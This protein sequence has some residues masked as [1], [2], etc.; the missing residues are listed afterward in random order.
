MTL[1]LAGAMASLDRG[2]SRPAR[3]LGASRL[4]V[5]VEIVLPQVAADAARRPRPVLRDDAV[6]AVGAA[7][8]QPARSRRCS[9]STWRSASTR[10]GDYAVANA[11]GLSCS[12]CIDA[13]SARGSTCGTRCKATE[14]GR[15]RRRIAAAALGRARLATRAACSRAA[16]PS[17]CSGRS[18]TSCC[19]RSPSAG[20]PVQAAGH[21]RPA[22][23]GGACSARP[24][25]PWRRSATSVW[26]AVL[27]VR[28]APRS[29]RCRPAMRW[30]G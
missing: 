5:L 11:L 25:T 23:L 1:L 8:G 21:L 10:Y 4:R 17:R 20:T 29:S 30:R 27:T 22:L 9:P 28:R 12:C 15:E 14:S 6:G 26:I 18:R 3:N 7:D 16:S 19:G 13:R 2:T 24:A